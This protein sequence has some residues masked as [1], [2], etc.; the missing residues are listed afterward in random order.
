MTTKELTD[1]FD[2]FSRLT[3]T[4]V[5][6]KFYDILEDL[7]GVMHN[8][9]DKACE[10]KDKCHED[11]CCEGKEQCELPE[12]K[13]DTKENNTASKGYLI[14][15]ERMM[16]NSDGYDYSFE[17]K[18]TCDE[19]F[20]IYNHLIP[21]L[22]KFSF[23][24][25]TGVMQNKTCKIHLIYIFKGI[26]ISYVFL[27]DPETFSFYGMAFG[28]DMLLCADCHAG[29]VYKF[30]EADGDL[31]YT[32]QSDL[33]K[34]IREKFD[35][36][37]QHFNDCEEDA[38]TDI[39]TCDEYDCGY[40]CS[41]R[42]DSSL[43]PFSKD[44]YTY[45]TADSIYEYLNDKYIELS[46]KIWEALIEGTD[47]VLD[48]KEFTTVESKNK[49]SSY[50]EIDLIKFYLSD[51]VLFSPDEHVTNEIWTRI[52]VLDKYVKLLKSR[53]HFPKVYIVSE[54]D[55]ETKLVA[56]CYLK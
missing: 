29:I 37:I 44:T 20:C 10:C 53:Y 50:P 45:P 11:K 32:K 5:S 3:S 7:L 1:L 15:Y 8:D 54:L 51:V 27:W 22:E 39:D 36:R 25:N 21:T 24:M 35:D 18:L 4:Q 42:S 33:P 30:I 23:T 49:E 14:E 46:D 2:E 38:N 12:E 34:Y 40:D 6:E 17:T 26:S 9:V 56:Y 43:N 47:R 55:D 16:T 48:Y 41:N 28:N 52:K 19:E 31:K 13:E